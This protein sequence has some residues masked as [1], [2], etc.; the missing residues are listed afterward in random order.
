MIKLS[1]VIVSWNTIELLNKCLFCLFNGASGVTFEVIVIDN[2]SYDGSPKM[3]EKEFPRVKLIRNETNTGFTKANNQGIKLAQGEYILLLHSDTFIPDNSILEKWIKFMD[4]HP[5]AGA[6]GCKLVL[7][8]GQHQVGDAGFAPS[9]LSIINYALFLSF[10]SPQKFKSLFLEYRKL[11]KNLSREIE[12]GWI[13]GAGLLVRRSALDKAG[14]LKEDLLM[15]T[16]DIELGSRIKSSGCKIFYLPYLE[17]IH[18]YGASVKKRQDRAVFSLRWIENLR[19]FCFLNNKGRS[20]FLYDLALVN[21]F[22]LRA[23][24]YRVRY[25]MEGDPASE[26]QSEQMWAYMKFVRKN[27]GKPANDH[28][29]R[30]PINR[31][32][33]A[34]TA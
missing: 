2:A 18:C 24:L 16:E 11:Y 34:G 23:A 12:V 30:P 32:A 1:I 7:P 15:F 19:R 13:N 28:T 21:G 20:L 22:F 3:V 6:S 31:A 9:L 10:L 14:P 25:M 8:N 4:L 29:L 27:F 5:E 33:G 26:E 17:L